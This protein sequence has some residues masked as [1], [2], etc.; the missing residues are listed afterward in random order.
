MKPRRSFL[1]VVFGLLLP[2]PAFAHH[3]M[4]GATP[5]TFVQGFVSGLAHPVIGLDHFLFLLM[6]GALAY[7]LKPPLRYATPFLFVVSALAGT[8]LHLGGF[9]LSSVAVVIV[10]TLIL[11]GGLV[12][13]RRR[14]GVL[15]SGLFFALAGMFH[16]YAYAESIVGAESAPLLAYLAGL[17]LIQGAIIMGMVTGLG[18][19]N[20]S[21]KQS[22]RARAERLAGVGG[23][24]FLTL[25]FV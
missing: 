9:D 19:L 15:A 14:M 7:S 22:Y 20:A 25:S 23:V 13:S 2:V 6:A 5:P 10:L 24:V 12:L 4:G 16:G 1:F 8:N 17:A 18:K 21:V 11:S 3:A